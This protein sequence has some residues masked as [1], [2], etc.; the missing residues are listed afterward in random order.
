MGMASRDRIASFWRW[1]DAGL[2]GESTIVQGARSTMIT[3][4]AQTAKR[5]TVYIYN[6]SIG[7]VQ[8]HA[9]RGTAE[10][11]EHRI[12]SIV[13]MLPTTTSPAHADVF[14][15]PACLV[16][17][18]F[19][20]R[21]EIAGK[22]SSMAARK[23]LRAIEASVLLDIA[24]VGHAHKPHVINAL[25]CRHTNDFA[26]KKGPM[27]A[28]GEAVAFHE[29]AY[30]T[31]WGGNDPRKRPVATFCPEAPHALHPA[32][33][34]VPYCQPPVPPPELRLDR[35]ISVVFIGSEGRIYW[36]CVARLD[37]T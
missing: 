4:T 30:P 34:H 23:A 35:S 9:S 15:H 36:S 18:F 6:S 24:Q 8:G 21:S 28:L 29:N 22:A 11:F 26:Y 10:F 1:R 19:V 5:P 7:C 16:T 27:S 13:R 3:E 17:A 25:R 37:L 31:L 12:P 33:L 2:Q 14:Y 20:A 32:A